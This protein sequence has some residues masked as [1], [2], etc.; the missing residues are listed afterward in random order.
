LLDK[1]SV[2][3]DN[4]VKVGPATMV[5]PSNFCNAIRKYE[6]EASGANDDDHDDHDDH[7]HRKLAEDDHDDHGHEEH[8]TYKK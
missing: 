3:H 7:G 4:F 8:P 2:P 5:K 6:A 1:D